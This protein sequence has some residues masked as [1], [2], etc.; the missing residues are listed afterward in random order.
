MT[1]RILFV[2]DEPK[3]LSALRRMLSGGQD[4][5]SLSFAGGADEALA[6]M[7]E[8]DFDVVV[9]D[10]NMP[11]KDGLTLIAEMRA[12]A[13]TAGVPVVVLTGRDDLDLKRRAL[14]SGA[15]DL[16]GKPVDPQDL[17]ARLR[18][19]IRLKR[20]QD[21][22]KGYNALLEERV[23][24]RTAE[25]ANSRI[26]VLWRLGR[27]GEYRDEQTGKHVVRVGSYCRLMGEA[28]VLDGDLIE[29]L[30]LASP[31][32]D[33][34]KIGIPH[35]VLLKPGPLSDEEWQVMKRHCAIGAEILTEH[36][37][38]LEAYCGRAGGGSRDDGNAILKTA[39]LIAL[40][41]HEKW[42]GT[43]YPAGLA[44]ER[45]PLISRIVAVADTFDAL[46]SKRPYKRALP[47]AEAAEI[48]R[49]ERDRQFDPEVCRAFETVFDGLRAVRSSLPDPG[50]MVANGRA[51]E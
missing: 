11:A 22:L 42:D 18:S 16:L 34:G 2:D 6:M 40:T 7:R 4:D 45:I 13:K 5:W 30:F 36:P 1:Q 26:E 3:V 33:I 8:S 31:L 10:V 37:G 38:A 17:V 39:A 48:V 35:D 49:G 9:T 28:L 15:I 14:E 41:H 20:L 25:L 21:E 43:G 29:T 12:N 27:A 46:C 24:E 32:H 47:E 51:P 19:V 44:G 23:A 50:V